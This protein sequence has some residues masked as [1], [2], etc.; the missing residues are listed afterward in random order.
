MRR[1]SYALWW[2]WVRWIFFPYTRRSRHRGH[3]RAHVIPQ[4][5]ACG[6]C[7]DTIIPVGYKGPFGRGRAVP[8]AS[9]PPRLARSRRRTARSGRSGPARPPVEYIALFQCAGLTVCVVFWGW[10]GGPPARHCTA[11]AIASPEPA[12]AGRLPGRLLPEAVAPEAL[13]ADVHKHRGEQ[14]GGDL[15]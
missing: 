4:P 10:G 13:A 2:F 15:G 11:T 7:G 14:G 3:T 9:H 5:G 6:V 8:S 1:N 12:A